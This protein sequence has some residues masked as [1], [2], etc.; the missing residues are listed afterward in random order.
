MIELGRKCNF[1]LPL[2]MAML[3][4]LLAWLFE[5]KDIKVLSGVMFFKL[6]CAS[7]SL[8]LLLKHRFLGLRHSL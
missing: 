4:F 6:Q 5:N 1:Y 3:K 8:E 7:E 2:N